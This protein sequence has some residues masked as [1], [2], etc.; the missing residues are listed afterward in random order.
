MIRRTPDLNLRYTGVPTTPLSLSRTD[1]HAVLLETVPA[2]GATGETAPGT[3]RLRFNEPVRPTGLALR[4]P[5]GR[6]IP[7]TTSDGSRR[8]TEI[9]AALPPLE[10]G[11]YYASW[12]AF[13]PDGHPIGGTVVRSEE[14][15]VGT[16]GDS[17]CGFR[18]WPLLQNK[19][20]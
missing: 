20:K 14:R 10:P 11:T 3:L 5:G 1:T 9:I 4:G 17:T 7:L 8:G 13:P 6:D 12:R 16:Q 19:K 15:H 18:C 2:D